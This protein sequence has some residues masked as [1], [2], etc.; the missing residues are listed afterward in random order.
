MSAF[1]QNRAPPAEATL[2]VTTILLNQFNNIHIQHSDAMLYFNQ[3]NAFHLAQPDSNF[4]RRK[5]RIK[6]KLD[7]RVPVKG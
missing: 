1:L 6:V 2:S 3:G 4:L 5:R 7:S